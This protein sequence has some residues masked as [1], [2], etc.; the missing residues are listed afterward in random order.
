MAMLRQCDDQSS[1][2]YSHGEHAFV[3]INMPSRLVIKVK[4]Q[5]LV[6]MSFLYP[7]KLCDQWL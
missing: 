3:R 7:I 2:T 1:D 5:R 4:L 6:S